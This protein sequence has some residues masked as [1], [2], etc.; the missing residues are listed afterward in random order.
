MKILVLGDCQSNG[1]NCLSD[2]ILGDNLPRTWSLRYHN[3]CSQALKWYLSQRRKH[4]IVD[5]ARAESIMDTTWAYIRKEELKVAWPSLLRGDVTNRS[6][7]GAHFIGYHKRLLQYIN[8]VGLPDRVLITDYTF[9]HYSSS[10][11]R[12]NTRYVFERNRF[13][14]DQEWNTKDYPI[15][16]H[17]EL[18]ARIAFQSN[19]PREW[20]LKKHIKAFNQLIRVLN[21]YRLKWSVVRFGENKEQNVDVFNKIMGTD[22]DCKDLFKQYRVDDAEYATKKLNCQPEI[23]K[24]VQNYIDNQM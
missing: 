17:K 20:H 24:R 6:V 13:Y 3:N 22:I 7:N 18:L 23:A 11:K 12:N 2:E 14:S 4:N 19:Q 9:A 15:D 21:H 16:V 1:N 8:T 5:S 10:F